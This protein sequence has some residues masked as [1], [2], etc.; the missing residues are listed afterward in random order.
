M[1]YEKKKIHL[2]DDNDNEAKCLF[3][4]TKKQQRTL[5]K[6]TARFV[7]R[8]GRGFGPAASQ[9]CEYVSCE[10]VISDLTRNEQNKKAHK[11]NK[12]STRSIFQIEE[13]YE[14]TVKYDVSHQDRVVL[15]L[16]IQM[17]EDVVFHCIQEL[18]R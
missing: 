4:K 1:R 3:I 6:P 16:W 17:R 5:E 11:T 9:S 2:D 18:L 14:D 10:Y 8:G 7:V 15:G 13:P 12:P